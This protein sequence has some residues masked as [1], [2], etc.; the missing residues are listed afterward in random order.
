MGTVGPGMRVASRGINI[1]I[2][3]LAPASGF[4]APAR[5]E[6]YTRFDAVRFDEWGCGRPP[7]R[8]ATGR[9]RAWA[10]FRGKYVYIISGMFETSAFR[11]PWP[12]EAR[13][14]QH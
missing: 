12:A 5:L 3:D 1:C 10:T 14:N 2:L 8:C 6:D 11:R 9:Q 4:A 7:I 13:G